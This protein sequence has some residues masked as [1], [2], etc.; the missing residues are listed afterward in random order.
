MKRPEMKNSL[1]GRV[2]IADTRLSATCRIRLNVKHIKLDSIACAAR[3]IRD[4]RLRLIFAFVRCR[5]ESCLTKIIVASPPGTSKP[6]RAAAN[7]NKQSPRTIMILSGC[8]YDLL[9]L[10]LP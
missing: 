10:D 8:M 3:G 7:T 5:I 2:L 6:Q 1:P 9:V 4:H